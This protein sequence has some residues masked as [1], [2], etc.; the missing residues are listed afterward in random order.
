MCC[1]CPSKWLFLFFPY[2]HH[3]HYY[4]V[5]TPIPFQSAP[6]RYTKNL[7]ANFWKRLTWLDM[8]ILFHY[9]FLYRTET[10]P[11]DSRTRIQNV[12]TSSSF[13]GGNFFIWV[14]K[15][16]CVLSSFKIKKWTNQIALLYRRSCHCQK[17]WH[18]YFHKNTISYLSIKS[19]KTAWIQCCIASC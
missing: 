9:M 2:H 14:H 16:V 13:R 3:H 5:L 11:P 6:N 8:K 17:Y 4:Y 15:F 7:F 18:S 12:F 1:Q 10:V 19:S